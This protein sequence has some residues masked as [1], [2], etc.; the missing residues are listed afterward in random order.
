MKI[1]ISD[2]VLNV[3]SEGYLLKYRCNTQRARAIAKEQVRSICKRQ[4]A[5]GKPSNARFIVSLGGCET[6]CIEAYAN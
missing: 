6:I 3:L 5:G 4:I 2:S 1:I